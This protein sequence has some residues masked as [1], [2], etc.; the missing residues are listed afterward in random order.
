MP[1][2]HRPE[3]GLRQYQLA[4]AHDCARLAYFAEHDDIKSLR[5]EIALMKMVIEEQWNAAQ[6]PV[7]G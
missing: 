2:V 3:K 4:K 6:T 5:D 7:N 1:G